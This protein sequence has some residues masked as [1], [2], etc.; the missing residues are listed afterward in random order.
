VSNSS[1]F[2]DG[3]LLCTNPTW[4]VRSDAPSIMD[5]FIF[6]SEAATEEEVTRPIDRDRG[7]T[8][9]WNEKG[10]E[11]SVVKACLPLQWVASCPL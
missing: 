6:S 7:K 8:V 2:T 11:G 9:A 5:A 4:R 3:N 10:K 1:A